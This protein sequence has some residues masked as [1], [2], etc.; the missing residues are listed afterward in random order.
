M[1]NGDNKAMECEVPEVGGSITG[2]LSRLVRYGAIMAGGWMVG[3]GWLGQDTVDA[4][5]TIFI[6]VTLVIVGVIIGRTNRKKLV[7]AVTVAKGKGESE[8]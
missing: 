5:V 4:A 6:T 7:Q 1:S 2:Q 3:K 8:A